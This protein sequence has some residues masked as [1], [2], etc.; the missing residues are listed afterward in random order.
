MMNSAAGDRLPGMH[1]ATIA[2]YTYRLYMK[3]ENISEGSSGQTEIWGLQKIQKLFWKIWSCYLFNA[4]INQPVHTRYGQQKSII[5]SMK[6]AVV[7]GGSRGIGKAV[8]IKLASDGLHV[9]EI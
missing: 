9:L 8:C 3:Y 6:C 1:N 7:T 5:P 4:A 2:R